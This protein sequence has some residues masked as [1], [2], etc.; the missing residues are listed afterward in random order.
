MCPK[1]GY[2][3]HNYGTK[4]SG[5]HSTSIMNMDEYPLYNRRKRF[6]VIEAALKLSKADVKRNALAL[7]D[8]E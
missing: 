8:S 4:F 1:C 2:Q 3:V 5:E 7:F 6:S